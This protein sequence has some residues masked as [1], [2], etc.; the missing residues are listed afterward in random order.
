VPGGTAG[1]RPVEHPQPTDA[2][3]KELYATALWCGQPRC[4][5]P[6]YRPSETGVRVL[7]SRVA[8]IHAR[9]ENGP[10]WNPAMTADEN[11][12]YNNLIVL[13]LAH[14]SE[15]DITPDHFPVEMLRE[16]KRVQVETQERAA[17][18]RPPLTDAEAADVIRRSFELEDLATLAELT[19][20]YAASATEV[21]PDMLRRDLCGAIRPDDEATRVRPGRWG[22]TRRARIAAACGVAGIVFAVIMMVYLLAG[23][24]IPP[25]TP[26]P[27]AVAAP[28]VASGLLTS[29]DMARL[30]IPGFP[31][32]E[33]G[34]RLPGMPQS[35]PS[36]C[37]NGTTY[38]AYQQARVFTDNQYMSFGEIIDAFQT[39]D[40]ATSAYGVDERG[41]MCGFQS[42]TPI[43]NSIA[44]LCDAR[45]AAAAFQ[46][47]APMY[48]SVY[49]A[50]V[51]C[52]RYEL[53]LFMETPVQTSG[54]LERFS[55]YAALAVKQALRMPGARV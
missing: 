36:I 38:Y 41:L 16:W 43:S 21:T 53:I 51:L 34:T 10:R 11:R 28:T 25:A 18:S 6:L 2:T 55:A 54:T 37:R 14:A 23:S 26:H 45:Y 49:A 35:E 17:Q 40:A 52:G 31:I 19:R 42:P 13:C 3:V 5:Q 44:G 46:N 4:R 33:R 32:R 20:R 8:H 39:A 48:T 50:T 15:I 9:R 30:E 24:P 47:A 12:S 1:H 22:T 29:S 7:N 27:G